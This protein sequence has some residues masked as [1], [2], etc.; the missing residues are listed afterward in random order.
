MST[1]FHNLLTEAFPEMRPPRRN[2][3]FAA[4]LDTPPVRVADKRGNSLFGQ[5]ENESYSGIALIVPAENGLQ[6][7]TE[8]SVDYFGQPVSGKICRIVPQPDETQLIG[9]EWL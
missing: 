9:I 6:V 5:L 2:M 1:E 7:E 4:A 3:R 8:V